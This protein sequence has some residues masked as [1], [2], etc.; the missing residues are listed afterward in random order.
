MKNI[1]L[2][3][4]HLTAYLP[5]NGRSWRHCSHYKVNCKLRWIES[6]RVTF[7][8]QK[9]VSTSYTPVVIS[10]IFRRSWCIW[11][12]MMTLPPLLVVILIKG[13]SCKLADLLSKPVWTLMIQI[14]QRWMSKRNQRARSYQ[15]G[16]SASLRC[17][18]NGQE[19]EPIEL[20]SCQPG[21]GASSSRLVS[22]RSECL[23]TVYSCGSGTGAY[24][25]V[26]LPDVSQQVLCDCNSQ[27]KGHLFFSYTGEETAPLSLNLHFV[28]SD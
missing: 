21:V 7:C 2:T 1:L 8:L 24:Y 27:E 5:M 11:P 9:E 10:I 14:R 20:N 22:G 17:D 19:A 25:S 15:T 23:L 6:W 12:R 26:M 16:V 13:L 18:H 3:W 28:L 4:K